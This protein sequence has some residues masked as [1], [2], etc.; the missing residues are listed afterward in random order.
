MNR[1]DKRRRNKCKL[2]L[3]FDVF[4]QNRDIRWREEG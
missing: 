4:F 2:R 3:S 1:I